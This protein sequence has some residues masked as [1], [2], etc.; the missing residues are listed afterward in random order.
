MNSKNIIEEM[1]MMVFLLLKESIKEMQEGHCSKICISILPN[2]YVKIIDNGRGIPLVDEVQKSNEILNRIF[3]GQPM[4]SLNYLNIEDFNNLE[5]NMVNSLRI[6][7][8]V[9][10]EM[11][12]AILNLTSM[13]LLKMS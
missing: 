3:G 5:L 13:E 10:G 1:H 4:S 12:N 6:C 7:P 9:Y 2:N 11:G 8:F